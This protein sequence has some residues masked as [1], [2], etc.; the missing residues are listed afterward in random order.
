MKKIKKKS[1][2]LKKIKQLEI[3]D[4][5]KKIN[6]NE[7]LVKV[8]SCGICSSDLKFIYTG[9]RIKKF[10]LILGHEISGTIG[11][12]KHIIFGAEIP[13]KKCPTC[14]KKRLGNLCDNPQ[15]VGSNFDGGIS[16][17]FIIKKSLLKKIPHI[18]Y[19]KKKVLKYASLAESLACVINGLELTNFKKGSSVVI[20]GAGYMGL[21]FTALSKIKKAKQILVID[22]D[23]KRLK[24]AKKLGANKTFKP[25]LNDK[26]LTKKILKF[27]YGN[28][29]DTVISANNNVDSHNLACNLVAKGGYVN[30][31]GGIPKNKSNKISIDVNFIH[32]R[33]AFI[34]GS[35]SSNQIHLEKAFRIIK[36]NSIDFSKIITSYANFD[37][38]MKKI[39]LLKNRKEI[40]VLFKPINEKKFL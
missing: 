39:K 11:K 32:Y 18:I 5:I 6:K 27:S 16:N 14:K 19:K 21:L 25:S 4:E 7:L 34:S 40:K 17:Y 35:F 13:C 36:N 38:F 8:D 12:N 33:Q 22:F 1:I 29:F 23:K 37:N 3:K 30:I 2:Y 9:S 20:I 28:G 15:S 10:P 26:N 31:F 24:L